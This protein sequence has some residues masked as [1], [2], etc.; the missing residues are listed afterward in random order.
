MKKQVKPAV[1]IVVI[2]A[3]VVIASAFIY[4]KAAAPKKTTKVSDAIKMPGFKE[5]MQKKWAEGKGPSD[6]Q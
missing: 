3:V 1:A 2:A 6:G 5:A 4:Q